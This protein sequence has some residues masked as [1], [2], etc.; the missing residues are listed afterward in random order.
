M[1]QQTKGINM[2]LTEKGQDIG[3]NNF[4]YCTWQDNVPANEGN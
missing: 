1:Y 4:G 3:V 2:C